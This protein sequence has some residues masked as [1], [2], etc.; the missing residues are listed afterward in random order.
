[1]AVVGILLVAEILKKIG[2]HVAL[3]DLRRF[4]G[5][6]VQ[7]LADKVIMLHAIERR[8]LLRELAG[9]PLVEEGMVFAVLLVAPR[10]QLFA[11]T[12]HGFHLFPSQSLSKKPLFSN[13][14]K[15]LRSMRSSGFTFF[16]R[17]SILAI[18]SRIPWNASGRISSL[19][20]SALTSVL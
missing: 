15:Y 17:G 20:S 5:H 7:V 16:A 8:L 19:R 14:C 2:L 11:K 6:P 1:M 10:G 3:G 4:I 9:G 18:S 12:R 13:S